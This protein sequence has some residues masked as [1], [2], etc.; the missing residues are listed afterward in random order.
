M[1]FP[2]APAYREDIYRLIDKTFDV[3]WYF[4]GNAKRPLKLLNYNLLK[5]VELKFEE[6]KLKKGFSYFKNFDTN[7]F[8]SYDAII[9]SGDVRILS[10]WKLLF[11]KNWRN[12]RPKM[13]LWTHGWYGRESKIKQ[14]I[15]KTYWKGV[16][17][18]LLYGEYAKKLMIQQGFNPNSLYVIANSLA[19]DRQLILRNQLC[20]SKIYNE[21][22]HNNNKTIIFIGRLTYEKKLEML[23]TAISSL[24]RDYLELNLVLIGNGEALNFLKSFAHTIGID[25][26]VYFWGE[27][28]DEETNA[29]LIYNADLCV[30]PGN[31]GL[32]AIHSMM[33]GCPVITHNDFRHQGP[34]FEAIKSGKTGIFFKNNSVESLTKIIKKWINTS[35]NDREAVREAC[36]QEID[37]KWN[38]NYQIEV[39]K[40]VLINT[41]TNN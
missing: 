24:K 15:K 29:K 31:V 30:S 11:A 18:F 3:D 16:D 8:D 26:Q 32:T 28:Y 14:W 38:P 21:I 25:S 13:I 1:F 27:C 34:E 12:K 5:N 33:F 41:I 40:S 36:F 10:F 17:A 4:C 35:G 37:R 2:Y 19:Y 39:L 7:I 23:I 6:V 22:F 20:S 9:F